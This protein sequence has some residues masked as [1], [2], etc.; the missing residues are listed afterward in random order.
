M[1]LK[2]KSLSSERIRTLF[3]FHRIERTKLVNDRLDTYDKKKYRAKRR[4]L[5]GNLNI[6][7]KVLVLAEKIPKKLAPRKFY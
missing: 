2:K 1:K 7:K 4:N 6:G 5:S 3:N